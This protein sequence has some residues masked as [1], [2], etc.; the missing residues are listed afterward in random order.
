M[1]SSDAGR[2]ASTHL[3][4]TELDPS[5]LYSSYLYDTSLKYA[6]FSILCDK[7]AFEH[8][9]E[10]L[11]HELSGSWHRPTHEQFSLILKSLPNNSTLSGLLDNLIN[12][13]ISQSSQYGPTFQGYFCAQLVSH[14]VIL[15]GRF[16]SKSH[17]VI[18]FKSIS[19]IFYHSSAW[20]NYL[21]ALFVIS[22]LDKSEIQENKLKFITDCIAIRHEPF[23][24]ELF[25]GQPARTIEMIQHGMTVVNTSNDF[26]EPAW[27]ELI[28]IKANKTSAA[29]WDDEMVAFLNRNTIKYE[30]IDDKIF[31]KEYEHVGFTTAV[32]NIIR[33]YKPS[34]KNKETS[35]KR[36]E[37]K[38]KVENNNK[39]HNVADH[40][41]K[42][43]SSNKIHNV[44]NSETYNRQAHFT[45]RMKRPAK[46]F[47]RIFTKI[48]RTMAD[49]YYEERN[50]NRNERQAKERERQETERDKL[51]GITEIVNELR[52][53]LEIKMKEAEKERQRQIEEQIRREEERREKERETNAWKNKKN[54]MMKERGERAAERRKGMNELE[55][56]NESV[57]AASIN[58]PLITNNNEVSNNEVGKTSNYVAPA[59]VYEI[60]DDGK[61]H[62]SSTLAS[63]RARN[64]PAPTSWPTKK[65]ANK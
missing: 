41:I 2:A 30:I 32:Y 65:P 22:T 28:K 25:C 8:A 15:N 52:K 14:L 59:S 48:A 58:Q 49:P 18:H 47:R 10:I 7:L 42:N 19:T 33:K 26:N 23:I 57:T 27:H 46:Q 55:R 36:D 51:A 9:L 4:D 21:N 54:E 60:S 5:A 35:I 13:F 53:E 63:K 45:N 50:R 1:D 31:V 24:R 64:K 34:I 44:A 20:F 11:K 12:F 37:N 62:S 16:P 6:V 38:Q 40:A 29:N 61:A 17:A 43:E 39:I 56:L 3:L